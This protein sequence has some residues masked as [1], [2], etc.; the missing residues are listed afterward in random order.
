MWH[1]IL[2]EEIE[3]KHSIRVCAVQE[4]EEDWGNW[5]IS[6]LNMNVNCKGRIYIIW[7]KDLL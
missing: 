1:Q 5:L 6:D 3:I 2:K 4:E 7:Y